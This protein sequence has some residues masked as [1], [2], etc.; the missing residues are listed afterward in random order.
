MSLSNNLATAMNRLTDCLNFAE[1]AAELIE[2]CTADMQPTD[3][4]LQACRIMR[5]DIA[6]LAQRV[7]ERLPYVCG[8]SAADA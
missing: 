7:Q 1:A 5:E 4:M 3:E 8:D 2:T 6:R